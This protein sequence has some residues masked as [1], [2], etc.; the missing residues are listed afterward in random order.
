E[1]CKFGTDISGNNPVGNHDLHIFLI[2][3]TAGSI[4][5]C[6]IANASGNGILLQD[7]DNLRIQDNFIGTNPSGN[8]ALPNNN[9]IS[10]QSPASNQ[11]DI[12]L[13][14]IAYNNSRGINFGGSGSFG[15]FIVDNQI[16]CNNSGGIRLNGGNLGKGPPTI[17]DA[18]PLYISGTGNEGDRIQI[19]KNEECDR[20]QG[21]II[22]GTVF[23]SGGIWRLEQSQF[24]S[25]LAVGDRIT[26]TATNGSN[27]SS[28]FT[29]A[30]SI[31]DPLTVTNTN[32][33]GEGS[34]RW[35]ITNANSIAASNSLIFNLPGSGPWEINLQSPLPTINQ[36]LLM[37][38]RTQANWNWDQNRTIVLNGA[39]ISSGSATLI[40]NAANTAIYGFEFVNFNQDSFSG[41][42]DISASSVLIEQNVFSNCN[43]AIELFSTANNATIQNNRIGTIANGLSPALP[44]QL[45]IAAFSTDGLTLDNNLIVNSSSAAILVDNVTNSS[46][47]DNNLGITLD[48]TISANQDGI[49]IQNAST[50]ASDNILIQGN[51]LAYSNTFGINFSSNSAGN[52]IRIKENTIFCNG[53]RGIETAGSSVN[54]NTASIQVATNSLIQGTGTNG[55]TIEVYV[56]PSCAMDQGEIFLGSTVVSGG[57]WILNQSSFQA[58]IALGNQVTM[59]RTDNQGNT[60]EFSPPEPVVDPFLVSNINDSGVGSLRDALEN[61]NII[62]GKQSL[63]FSLPGSGPWQ[64]NL[65]SPLP[66]ISESIT[67][68]ARTQTNWNWN[69]NQT[70]ILNGLN[71]A[72]TNIHGLRV[73]ASN[74][75][76]Y[77][78]EFINFNADQFSSGLN[79]E[80][81]NV[82]AE[83]NIFRGNN[84]GIQSSGSFS[85]VQIINNRFGTRADGF[86][87][88]NPNTVGLFLFGGNNYL[89]Q[90]NLISNSPFA[91]L[92]IDNIIDS[93]ILDNTIGLDL[94]GNPLPNQYGIDIQDGVSSPSERILIQNNT[95]AHNSSD[96]IWFFSNDAG[97]QIQITQNSIFC[98]TNKG[99]ETQGAPN[100]QNPGQIQ[101]ASVGFIR[102]TGVNGER[103]EV[104][105]NASCNQDQGETFLGSTTVSGGIWQLDQVNYQSSLALGDVVTM[106]M[107]DAQNNTS[108]F[109]LPI[110][111]EAPF[112]VS[113]LNDTGAGSFRKAIENANLIPG[114]QS[115]TFSLSGAGPWQVNLQSPLPSI[116]DTITIDA[117]TQVNWNWNLNR[118]FILNGLNLTGATSIH[119]LAI[120]AYGSEVHGIEFINFNANLTSSGL[121]IGESSVIV[122][123]NVFRGNNDGIRSTASITNVNISNNRFGTRADGFTNANPNRNGIFIFRGDNHSIQNNL[124]SNSTVAGISI[125]NLQDS[126]IQNNSIGLDL[127]GNSL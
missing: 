68:D 81:N 24:A 92:L 127:N 93:Q 57:S 4:D 126:Q 125:D 76:I 17:N 73:T 123:Q 70:L 30:R 1:S 84:D 103:V 66:V 88:A 21:E 29:A 20:Q 7:F 36:T 94:N 37:D 71:L 115:L 28:E 13:N 86:S 124:I 49:F 114:K 120:E 85:N 33:A 80:A 38:A 99:I 34:L 117:R 107:T 48:G 64:I 108:E 15:V 98:N 96:G 109:S 101:L 89:I 50:L 112:T 61:A 3:G 77:G 6:V 43:R 25:T 79:I 31:V 53:S 42:V 110:S 39:A 18:N 55:D 69:L 35:A 119:G 111:V 78:L 41:G 122:T 46:I 75:E 113:N 16:Y 74:S 32:D 9:G 91:G 44:S 72:G 100:N 56:N 118:T 60:S 59:T 5:N 83:Q 54:Q 10:F 67:I 2:R 65:Q 58:T 8:L 62:N 121:R 105:V 26:A 23:V 95:I 51:T 87:T 27:N 104:Y 45:G 63:V 19:F 52:R 40:I 12:V 90:N 116:T 14:T 102:G 106:T 22:L 82:T 11:I 97:D 47:I